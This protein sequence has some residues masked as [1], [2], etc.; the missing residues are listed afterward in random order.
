[1]HRRLRIRSHSRRNM[2]VALSPEAFPPPVVYSPYFSSTSRGRDRATH[3]SWSKRTNK[4]DASSAWRTPKCSRALPS[5]LGTPNQ[6][7]VLA[8]SPHGSLVSGRDA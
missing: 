2:S 3:M 8:A 1:M 7:A 4:P 5:P 6:Q